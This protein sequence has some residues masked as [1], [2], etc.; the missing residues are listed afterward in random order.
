LRKVL[1]STPAATAALLAALLLGGPWGRPARALDELDFGLEE[2]RLSR[3]ELVGNETFSASELKAILQIQEPTWL[4]PLSVPHYRPDLIGAQVRLLRRY[5]EKRGFHQVAVQL[6]SIAADPQGRGDTVFFSI[7]EGPRTFIDGVYFFGAES[8]PEKELRRG[9][10]L[11][12]GEPAPADLN[13][14]GQDL[15]TLRSFFWRH[16]HLEVQIE[17]VLTFEPTDDPERFT[18]FLEYRITPGIP[19]RVGRIVIEGN[20]RTREQLITRELKV[21]EGGPFSWGAID[22]SRRRLLETALFRDISFVPTRLDSAAGLADLTVRVVERRPAFYELGAGVGS[23]ER[24][25]LLGAWGHNNLWGSGRRLHV[26]GKV[27]WTVEEIVGSARGEPRPE[28]NY[29]TDVYYINPHLRGSRYQLDVNLFLEKETRGE[30]G[31]NLQTFGASVGTHFRPRPW[32][33]NTVALQLEVDNPQPHPDATEVKSVFDALGIKKTQTNSAVYTLFAEGRD[34]AF[35]PKRGS[36]ATARVEIAGGPLAGDNSFVKGVAAWHGY[37]ACPLGGVLAF[38]ISAGAVGAYGGS[39]DRGADGVPYADRFFAGGVSSV[40]GYAE[41]SLGPRLATSDSLRLANPDL[42]LPQ[43]PARGGNY[44]LLTNVEWRFPLPWL[45]RWK[46][47][48]VLFCDGG[49]VWEK[50]GDIRL[51]SFR[52][53][54]YPRS[55]TDPA[56]TRVWDYRFSVGTGLRLDTPFGPFRIDVGFPLKRMQFVD[57]A[58]E[59]EKTE[60]RVMYHFSLGYPF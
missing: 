35:R 16:A 26:R 24:V 39:A 29:R 44:L 21:E 31:M 45:S 37:R 36:L 43:D 14:L 10:L 32:I 33:L 50:A 34:D 9:L 56:A 38:R 54:S 8:F 25:R 53:R 52:L 5:Y 19:Y 49:N 12:E 42:I 27:F 22:D 3:I 57:E 28:F 1:V 48:G 15:Y 47:G 18:A 2:H 55:P 59:P 11:L 6:D 7:D 46:L 51:R 60:D 20:V 40:R 58:G 4:R 30:S 41:S 13:D 23:R 17:P